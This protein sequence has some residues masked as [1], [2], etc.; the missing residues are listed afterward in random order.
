MQPVAAPASGEL[1]ARVAVPG[2]WAKPGDRVLVQTAQA[3]QAYVVGVLFSPGG[4]T[5]AT[6]A[7]ASASI[8]DERIALRAADG[9][10]L[11]VYEADSGVLELSAPEKLTL[12]MPHGRVAIEAETLSV[13]AAAAEWA[14][15]QWEL[16]AERVVERARD[17]FRTVEG[18][19]ETRAHRARILVDRT[20]EL[21]ARR[22]SVRSDEDTRIDGKRVLLG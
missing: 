22:A 3:D 7:G 17:A 9:A 14:V 16:R 1:A 19:L 12:H 8:D 11:A 18:L 5:I 13:R 6:A 2:Y 20:L 4:Q 10:L 15:G 21:C